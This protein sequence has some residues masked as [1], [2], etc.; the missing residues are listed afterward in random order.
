MASV[1]AC[2]G[3]TTVGR[4]VGDVAVGAS[5]S[6]WNLGTLHLLDGADTSKNPQVGVCDPRESLLDGL[7][8]V[9][10]SLETSIG[11]VVAF[12]SEAHSSTVG[13]TSSGQ[14]VEAV[15]H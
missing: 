5:S 13:A 9:A 3:Q 1:L 10:G 11:A 6:V 8:E 12:G 7:K 14:L 4:A 2:V 15:A